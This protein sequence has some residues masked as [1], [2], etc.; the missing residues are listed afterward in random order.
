MKILM[1]AISNV[2]VGHR[3]PTPALNV[4]KIFAFSYFP[5]FSAEPKRRDDHSLAFTIFLHFVLN[6]N[7]GKVFT[8]PSHF[9]Y[10]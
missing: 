8:L 2:G 10:I 4:E 1:R 6:L 5:T 9:S 3:F 7:G